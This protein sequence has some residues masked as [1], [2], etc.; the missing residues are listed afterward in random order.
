MKQGPVQSAKDFAKQK[1]L[2]A[3]VISMPDREIV[4]ICINGARPSFKG[5]VA[6]AWPD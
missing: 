5:D 1:Q 3:R 2:K 6:M 4:G